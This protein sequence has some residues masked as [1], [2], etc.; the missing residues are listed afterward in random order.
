MTL[1]ANLAWFFKE[2]WRTYFVAL[3]MLAG[4][5]LLN[6]AVPYLIG[7]AIDELITASETSSGNSDITPYLLALF[8]TRC[9]RLW[10]TLRLE[11]HFV[12][13]LLPARQHSTCSLLPKTKQAG[14][15]LLQRKQHW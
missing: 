6:L 13:Y 7:L 4:V 9:W 8:V 1:F 11:T 15:G 3:L 14:P 2:H 10:P 5:A 12:R